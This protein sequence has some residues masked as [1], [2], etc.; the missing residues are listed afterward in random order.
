M[1]RFEVAGILIFLT[2]IASYINYRYVKLPKSIGITSVTLILSL[3]IIIGSKIG[4][5]IRYTDCLLGGVKFNETF[6]NGML[7]F[8]LFAGSLHLCVIELSRYKILITALATFSVLFSTFFIGY[9]LYILT[10]IFCVN[11]PFYYCFAFGALIS[12]TDPIAVLGILKII[13]APRSLEIKIAGEALFNDGMGI[14]L[15]FI[16]LGFSY[17]KN[18]FLS[19]DE[20]FV[21]FIRQGIGGLVL[22][23][24]VGFFSSKLLRHV[25][26]SEIAII[27][28]LGI[29]TGGYY[30]SHSIIDVS[31]PICM[32]TAGL[33]ISNAIKNSEMTEATMLRLG[34]F[35][36]LLDEVLNAILFVLI[37]LEFISIKFDLYVLLLAISVVIIILFGRWISILVPIFCLSHFKMINLSLLNVLTWS[38]LRGGVSIA[39][40]LSIDSVYHNFIVSITYVVVIFSII[41]QGF[42]VG[43]VIKRH[44]RRKN[45]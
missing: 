12:P 4:L 29:V 25:N 7:S 43:S 36:E 31:G 39:L 6:L 8:L 10:Q 20:I 32:A 26:D 42:T 21:Y 5:N 22:G 28:T 24:F 34:S 38:G 19:L 45:F 18:T 27:F 16:A 3:F 30:L 17:G 44:V 40:A 9:F 14:V 1:I 11:L 13:R 35:W 33:V 23:L 15:F 37:G 2:A 41:V